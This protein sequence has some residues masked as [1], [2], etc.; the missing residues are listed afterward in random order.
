[1]AGHDEPFWAREHPLF[2]RLAA[3]VAYAPNPGLPPPMPGLLNIRWI[4]SVACCVTQDDAAGAH[5]FATL[6]L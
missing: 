5:S 2:R 6:K 4:L 1:M 3:L